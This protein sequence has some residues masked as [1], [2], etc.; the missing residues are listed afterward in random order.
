MRI[1][2]HEV[3]CRLTQ[4]PRA[5]VGNINDKHILAFSPYVD[6]VNVDK[7]IAD[8][9]RQAARHQPLLSMVYDRIPK[10]RGIPGLVEHLR[11]G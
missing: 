1:I 3:D 4:L 2:W 9:L 6:A 5:E 8:M 10:R 7:R 11:K